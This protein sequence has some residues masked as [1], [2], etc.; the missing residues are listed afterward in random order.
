MATAGTIRAAVTKMS[1]IKAQMQ[2]EI[3][4]LY[5]EEEILQTAAEDFE[6]YR[7]HKDQVFKGQTLVQALRRSNEPL[8]ILVPDIAEDRHHVV[9]ENANHESSWRTL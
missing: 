9:A 1:D 6:W 3:F 2:E 8:G 5:E 4:K 7:Q